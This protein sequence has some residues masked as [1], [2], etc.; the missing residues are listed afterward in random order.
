[1]CLMFCFLKEADFM[2]LTEVFMSVKVAHLE[3][4]HRG[5][6]TLVVALGLKQRALD[7]YFA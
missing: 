7:E 3:L 2:M 1:M 4:A 6:L 5:N